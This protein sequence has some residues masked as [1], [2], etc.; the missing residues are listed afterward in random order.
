VCSENKPGSAW[1]LAVAVC[2]K[3]CVY[4]IEKSFSQ[5]AG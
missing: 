3:M 4:G 1:H 5:L 2:P